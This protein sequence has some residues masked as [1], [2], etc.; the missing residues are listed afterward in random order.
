MII[1]KIMLTRNDIKY[2]L[3][4]PFWLVVRVVM[5]VWMVEVDFGIN[6]SSQI[7]SNKVRDVLRLVLSDFIGIIRCMIGGK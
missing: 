3:I 1:I 6:F 2:S 4:R 5:L 7:K